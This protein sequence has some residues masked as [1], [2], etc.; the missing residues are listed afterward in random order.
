MQEQVGSDRWG[1][2]MAPVDRLEAIGDHWASLHIISV[3]RTLIKTL[4]GSP[5]HRSCSLIVIGEAPKAPKH[6]PIERIRKSL[7]AHAIVDHPKPWQAVASHGEPL[8]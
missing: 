2:A 8:R 3:P 6:K 1:L 5:G 4:R 7:R